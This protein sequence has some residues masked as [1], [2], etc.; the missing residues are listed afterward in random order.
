MEPRGPWPVSAGEG[1]Q[2][3]V[4]HLGAVQRS[5]K[6]K[7]PIKKSFKTTEE[8]NRA[9]QQGWVK[10]CLKVYYSQRGNT[11]Q[12]RGYSRSTRAVSS[13]TLVKGL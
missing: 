2:Q 1:E 10:A 3:T 8:P 12:I 7:P 6:E 11:T 5:C 9:V 4:N 13:K